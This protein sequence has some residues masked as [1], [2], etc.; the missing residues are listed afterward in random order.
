[1]NEIVQNIM[2]FINEHTL[3]LIG[4]CV[5][6]ILVLIG[7]LIDNSVKSKRVRNDIKNADQVPENI[8]EEIIKKAEEKEIKKEE[9]KLEEAQVNN[10]VGGELNLDSRGTVDNSIIDNKIIDNEVNPTPT[11]ETSSLETPFNLDTNQEDP[12][13]K[14]MGTVSEY[15][16][17]KTLADILMNVKEEVVTNNIDINN[18]DN[19]IFSDNSVDIVLN[20]NV[21]KDD[22]QIENNNSSDELDRIM[23]KLSTMNNNVEE[24]NYTNIF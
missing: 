12:D 14:I 4:I 24:D 8:K 11:L 6:L 18:S 1:M 17:D 20:E 15:T 21:K 7:Y 10:E 5:F 9:A 3:L 23:R 2:L 16:N 19:N 22:V 13:A